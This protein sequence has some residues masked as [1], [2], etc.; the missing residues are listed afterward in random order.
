MDHVDQPDQMALVA[1]KA[2]GLYTRGY[3]LLYLAIK[4]PTLQ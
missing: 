4:N 1:T 2:T 3:G